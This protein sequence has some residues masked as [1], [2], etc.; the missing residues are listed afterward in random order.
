MESLAPPEP[1]SPKSCEEVEIT[2]KGMADIVLD[3]WGHPKYRLAKAMI[4]AK[5]K[6]R[7]MD[8]SPSAAGGR[9]SSTDL[10]LMLESGKL[11]PG[12]REGDYKSALAREGL[13]TSPS[14]VQCGRASF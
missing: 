10:E 5:E 3:R 14:P 6:L 12:P 1:W 11:G 4:K 2:S 8:G 7:T 13:G 9:M